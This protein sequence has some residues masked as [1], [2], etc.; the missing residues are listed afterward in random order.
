MM[1][2]PYLSKS[3]Y[4]VGLQCYKLLWTHYNAKDELPPV[5]DQT[6]AVFDQGHEVGILAQKLFPNGIAVAGELPIDEAIAR[7]RRLVAERKPLFE[8]AFASG[9]TFAR[10]DVLNPVRGG[11]WDIIEVKS[12]TSVKDHYLDDVAFQRFCYEAAGVPIRRCYL[13]HINN[14]YIR[15]G[16]VDPAQL[17]T[18]EDITKGVIERAMGIEERIQEMLKV[19]A[20]KNCPE[21]GIGPHCSDPY[22][23]PFASICWKGVDRVENN[24][25]SLTRL[26]AKAWDLYEEGVVG[27]DEIPGD[28]FLSE[29]Q[30]LQVEAERAN[31][32]FIDRSA[33]S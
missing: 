18:K 14:E 16:D 33:V 22:G 5:D 29:R 7:S 2:K 26:G 28:F 25:F 3:K 10:V 19:I 1:S 4:L 12:S 6:Q 32:P 9:R 23:C 27:I 31:T 17:F 20:R 11:K 8:A 30:R 15:D 24:V 21:V 13:M